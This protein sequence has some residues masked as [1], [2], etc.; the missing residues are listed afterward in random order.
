MDKKDLKKG[1]SVS[2][3]TTRSEKYKDNR[4][5]KVK[6][7]KN[8]IPTPTTKKKET[9]VKIV[10]KKIEKPVPK[11][12][13]LEPKIVNETEKPKSKKKLKKAFSLIINIIMII[14][15]LVIIVTLSYLII[16]KTKETNKK[17]NDVIDIKEITKEDNSNNIVV[18]LTKDGEC[19]LD[20]E[21]WIKSN[22]KKCEFVDIY[23]LNKLYLKEIDSDN[24]ISIDLKVDYSYIE[25][26]EVNKKEM[27]LAVNANE[28]I[29][30]GIVIKGNISEN[31]TFA[32]E[33]EGVA[34]VD[35]T[36]VVTGIADGETN[37][38]VE[39]EGIEE[40]VK[41]KVSSLIIPVTEEFNF[42]KDYLTCNQYT[43]EQNDE[44][45]AILKFRVEQAGYKT[46]AGAVAAAR[47]IGLEFPYIINYF[48]ENG[49]YPGVDG[50][51]RYYHEGLYLNDSRFSIIKNSMHGPGVWGCYIH[52][53]PAEKE[54]RN[55]L[56]CSGFITWIIKQAGYSPGDLGAGISPGVEDMTDLGT[57]VK[58]TEDVVR[59]KLKVGDLLSGDGVPDIEPINGGH[60]AMVTG[61]K[62][63]DIFVSEELWWGTGYVGAVIRKYSITDLIRYFYWQVDMD[64]FYKDD[65]NLTNYWIN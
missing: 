63:D 38:K 6:K 45:D 25:K 11:E 55:G 60:I 13:V 24:V 14:F 23:T 3:P 20:N 50:E 19:S 37:I 46:R 10:K 51:G 65:G 12:K 8:T 7:E 35:S 54:I 5:D 41:V 59:N 61:I 43:K 28:K 44:L 22:K 32:S 1:N 26:F 57:K 36:G 18:H 30:Y 31:V 4:T 34:T 29:N 21:N 52:S 47:F 15:L 64:E 48:S 9:S 62:G 27:I 53:V 49:R 39:F 16:T 40:T 2:K 17:K 56:D 42:D 33:N 58:L